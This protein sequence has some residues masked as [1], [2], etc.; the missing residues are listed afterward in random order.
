MA[1]GVA[2]DCDFVVRLERP[3]E[4]SIGMQSALLRNIEPAV[5]YSTLFVPFNARHADSVDCFFYIF[6]SA[7]ERAQQAFDGGGRVVYS[8]AIAPI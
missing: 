6:R 4:C 7:G 2:S 1:T 3:A 8:Y 5:V